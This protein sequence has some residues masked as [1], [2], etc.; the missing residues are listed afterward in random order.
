ML[1]GTALQRTLVASG[2]LDAD[3]DLLWPSFYHSPY[4]TPS[5]ARTLLADSGFPSLHF[6]TLHDSVHWLLPT[7]Q[8]V[9]T[10]MGLPPPY[11]RHIPRLNRLRRLLH[12]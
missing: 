9:M 12:L 1:P 10:H 2:D 4:I 3:D 7:V 6:V 5:R 11:W 8:R